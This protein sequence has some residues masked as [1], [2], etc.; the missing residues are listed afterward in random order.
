MPSKKVRVERSTPQ[1]LFYALCKFESKLDNSVVKNHQ[2]AP[3]PVIHLY[4]L[5]EGYIPKAAE[6][7]KTD[8]TG[9]SYIS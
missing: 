7:I 9:G 2:R 1:E 5:T 6:N 3:V 8:S 4:M